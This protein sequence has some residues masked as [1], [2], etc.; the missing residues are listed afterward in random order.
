[1]TS[2]KKCK[3]DLEECDKRYFRREWSW[4][5]I[6][7][8]I[9]SCIAII[10]GAGSFVTKTDISIETIKLDV[11]KLQQINADIDTIKSLLRK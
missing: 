5:T 9:L 10:Y 2:F 6:G 8:V 1:M 7:F 4:K 11:S 3:E